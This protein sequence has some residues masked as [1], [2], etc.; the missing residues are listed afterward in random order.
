MVKKSALLVLLMLFGLTA[1]G[2]KESKIPYSALPPEGDPVRGEELFN[3]SIDRQ[4]SC[5]S[6]HVPDA[7]DGGA[8]PNLDGFGERAAIQVPGLSAREY[9][10]WS[11][12]E[13]HRHLVKNFGNAMP[14]KYDDKLSPQDIADLIAYLLTR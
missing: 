9:A 10:F 8:S 4:P 2:S 5:V 6:C 13:P 3:K 7:E 12:T 11:I 1:C 14:N